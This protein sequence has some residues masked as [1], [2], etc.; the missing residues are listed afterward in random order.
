[1]FRQTFFLSNLLFWFAIGSLTS[2]FSVRERPCSGIRSVLNCL[3]QQS[4]AQA[5]SKFYSES[6]SFSCN[7]QVSQV[8]VVDRT[9]CWNGLNKIW[10]R[11]LVAKS[12]MVNGE[13]F[14]FWGSLKV[15]LLE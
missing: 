3:E 10:W 9:L 6:G 12:R 14:G 8:V 1:M 15:V 4:V 13:L 11:L 5:L 7:L 2:T